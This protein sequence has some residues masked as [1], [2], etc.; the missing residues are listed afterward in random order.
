MASPALGACVPLLVQPG[1]PFPG[2]SSSCSKCPSWRRACR[3]PHCVW[4]SRSWQCSSSAQL[5]THLTA[6]PVCFP[7]LSVPWQ[8][9]RAF[10]L[11]RALHW[12]KP[13]ATS[14]QDAPRPSNRGL[15]TGLEP[16]LADPRT[17]LAR[18]FGKKD[19]QGAGHSWIGWSPSNMVTGSPCRGAAHENAANSIAVVVW[20]LTSAA[21]APV[22]G[23]SLLTDPE[24]RPPEPRDGVSCGGLTTHHP[25]SVC[26]GPARQ[27]ARQ[28][29]WFV[30]HACGD[31][32][33]L[34]ACVTPFWQA[35]VLAKVVAAPASQ[36]S[37]N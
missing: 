29:A 14:G 23:K 4:G 19:Q 1:L 11:R 30:G 10:G 33:K 26:R 28:R 13:C 17:L 27:Q 32:L 9:F 37:A 22:K 12:R 35:E 15:R 16:F 36:P 18:A 6:G 31:G 7:Q 3:W 8:L 5:R 34:L 20:Q 21:P 24:R 2:T 25:G